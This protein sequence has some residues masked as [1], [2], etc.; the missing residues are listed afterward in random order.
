MN[1]ELFSELLLMTFMMP[2]HDHRTDFNVFNSSVDSIP[3][4]NIN[5][6]IMK[7]MCANTADC[8]L[9]TCVCKHASTLFKDRNSKVASGNTNKS[10]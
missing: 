5:L 8:V 10:Q 4:L 9:T 2:Y 3:S 6:H 7:G 1:E